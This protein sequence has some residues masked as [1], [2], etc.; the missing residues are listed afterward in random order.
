MGKKNQK[1]DPTNAGFSW[2]IPN[3]NLLKMPVRKVKS[4]LQKVLGDFHVF[5]SSQWDPDPC[6]PNPKK[7]DPRRLATSLLEKP[8]ILPSGK[9]T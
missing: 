5:F 3:L 9:L 7:T 1:N 6:K 2:A 4:R 8:S